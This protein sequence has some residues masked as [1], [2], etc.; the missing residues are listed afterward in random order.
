MRFI[1]YRYVIRYTLYS[2][3][4]LFQRVSVH[5]CNCSCSCSCSVGTV[6]VRHNAFYEK[7]VLYHKP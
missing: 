5:N 1:R 2:T 4:C 3:S 6:H 7:N